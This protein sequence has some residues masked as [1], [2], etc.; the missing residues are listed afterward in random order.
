VAGL[1]EQAR[2]LRLG[3]AQ[4]LRRLAVRVRDDLARLVPGRRQ[5]L[6]ALPLALVAEALNLGLALLEVL[7]ALAD[8]L[9]GA[10]QLGRRGPLRVALDHVGE[11]RRL[12]DEVKGVHAHGMPRRVDL[13]SATR[14]LQHAQLGLELDDVAPE[15]VERLAHLLLVEALLDDRQLLDGGQ[16]RH[17]RLLPRCSGSLYTHVLNSWSAPAFSMTGASAAQAEALGL[18]VR[19]DDANP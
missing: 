9:L 19:S 4:F 15:G 16:R 13:R 7:L 5:N 8:L 10:L 1:L 3:L 2:T 14:G 11:L 17:R 12:A 18:F 6:V